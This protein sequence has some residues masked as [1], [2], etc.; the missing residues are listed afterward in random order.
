MNGIAGFIGWLVIWC[1]VAVAVC[2]PVGKLIA[3]LTRPDRHRAV[4]DEYRPLPTVPFGGRAAAS[5]PE[6]SSRYVPPQ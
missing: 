2:V 6:E 3:Y 5:G 1:A 4:G